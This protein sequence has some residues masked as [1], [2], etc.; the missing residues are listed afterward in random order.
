MK[1]LI[2]TQRVDINDDVLGFFHS[3]ILEFAKNCEKVTVICLEKGERDL[4]EHVKVLSLGK[5]EHNN[6]QLIF[7]FKILKRLKYL[8]NFYR[9]IWRERK[10]Y[11]IIFIHM[12]PQYALIGAPFWKLWGKKIGLWYAH[13]HTSFILRVS[14]KLVDVIFTSTK[15][16]CRIRSKKIKVVGQGIEINNSAFHNVA[17]CKSHDDNIFSIITVGRIS[18]VKDYKTILAAAEIFLK[19]VCNFKIDIVGQAGLPK[20]EKYLDSLKKLVEEKGLENYINFVGAVPNKKI[21]SFLSSAD[22]FVNMSR[23]GS[24]D[25][26]ILEAMAVKLPILTCNEALDEVLGIYKEV[27]MYKK[28]DFA[29]LAEKMRWIY[30][31]GSD[32]RRKIGEDLRIIVVKYHSLE[33]LIVKMVRFYEEKN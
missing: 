31:M 30:L 12:N 26:A 19:N 1:L 3:W 10:N 23:T 7:N 14:A 22:L 24:L 5:E 11:D 2:V 6:F 29:A 15:S 9:Y 32:E 16:G 25:K 8:L 27:L 4:P 17:A 28:G 21:G 20:H 13:G 18:P 33:Q